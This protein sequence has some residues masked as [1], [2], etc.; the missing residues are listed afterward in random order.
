MTHLFCIVVVAQMSLEAS[1]LKLGCDDGDK[2]L[3]SSILKQ[4]PE[5]YL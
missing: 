1:F 4:V 2:K 3:A 5:K